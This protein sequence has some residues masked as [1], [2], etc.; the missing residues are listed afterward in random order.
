[1][2]FK[3]RFVINQEDY[4]ILCG[5]YFPILLNLYFSNIQKLIAKSLPNLEKYS[6]YFERI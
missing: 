4:E 6:V 1:M 3:K 5:S 2:D